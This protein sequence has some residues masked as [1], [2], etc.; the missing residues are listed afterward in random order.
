MS[1]KKENRVIK[2]PETQKEIVRL[3]DDGSSTVKHS[4]PT[5]V[6]PPPPPPK[7]KPENKD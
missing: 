3:P 4:M 1:S 7:V 5:Y 6:A 2:I